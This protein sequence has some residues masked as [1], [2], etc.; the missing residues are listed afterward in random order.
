MSFKSPNQ[1][2]FL[3]ALDSDRKKSGGQPL[4]QKQQPPG[5]SAPPMATLKSQHMGMTQVPKL[6]PPNNP[7][8]ATAVPSLPGL[9]KMPKFGKVKNSLKGQF[10]IK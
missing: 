1:R 7:M 8:S 9:N 10:K 4:G 3:Y 6:P 2:K 5:M